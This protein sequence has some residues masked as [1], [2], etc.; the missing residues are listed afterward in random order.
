M[1]ERG[2]IDMTAGP[3]CYWHASQVRTE[4]VERP[5]FTKVRTVEPAIPNDRNRS[6]PVIRI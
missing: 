5:I 4:G 6:N 1:G 3:V 2:I